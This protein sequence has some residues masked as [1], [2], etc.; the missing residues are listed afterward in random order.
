MKWDVFVS[1]AS[2]DKAFARELV[3]AL[4]ESG[5][6]VWFDELSLFA[7]DSLRRA[8]NQGLAESEYGIVIL[9]P[10]FLAKEWPQ[11]ELDGLTARED[12]KEKVI[13]PIWH[14]VSAEN[15]RK[16]SP[17]LA[18]KL[19]II[20]ED[21]ISEVVGKILRAIYQDRHALEAWTPPSHLLPDGTELV[22]LPM[23]PISNFALGIAK[24]PITNEQYKDFISA[25]AHEAPIGESFKAGKW[26]GPFAPLETPEFSDSKQ[27]VVCVDFSDAITYCQWVNRLL[28]AEDSA[29]KWRRR[30]FLPLTEVWD[31]AAFGWEQEQYMPERL[32][33]EQPNVHHNSNRPVAIDE[34]GVRT[35]KRGVSDMFGNIWEWVISRFHE[36]FTLIIDS[37]VPSVSVE[38]RGGGFLD[39]LRN[40][41]NKPA[42]A[43]GRLRKGVGTRHTDLGFRIA[44]MIDIGYLTQEE[45]VKLSLQKQLPSYIWHAN[46]IAVSFVN[47]YDEY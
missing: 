9:S 18:D 4:E 36:R 8:I 21:D 12:G 45:K 33:I 19:S 5:L 46:Q 14:N 25:T 11:K 20:S 24:H 30:V 28:D 23:R 7:G 22:L 32:F 31:L 34:L 35:N 40:F 13:I 39:D 44:A 42:L 37:P 3:N 2:E 6:R 15:V 27:P 41:K 17:I 47:D 26:R 16:F 38:L 10:N 29:Q 1:H 43:A